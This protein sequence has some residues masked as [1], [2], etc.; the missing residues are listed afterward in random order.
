MESW[1]LV[2]HGDVGL[3]ETQQ[4]QPETQCIYFIQL[5]Q[6]VRFIVHRL[7]RRRGAGYFIQLNKEVGLANLNRCFCRR[8]TLGCKHLGGDRYD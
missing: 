5:S 2:G 6:G 8:T 3:M 7:T 1:G 4:Q